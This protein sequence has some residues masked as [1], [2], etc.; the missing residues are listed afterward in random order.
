MKLLSLILSLGAVGLA[1]SAR[2]ANIIDSIYGVGAGSFELP[3]HGAA[4]RV[5]FE[6]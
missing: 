6:G 2:A 3:G 1:P 5:R 4:V